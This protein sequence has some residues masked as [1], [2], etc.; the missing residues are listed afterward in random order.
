MYVCSGGEWDVVELRHAMLECCGRRA[1]GDARRVR[2]LTRVP[3]RASWG[4]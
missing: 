1:L 3:H 4:Q 2:V